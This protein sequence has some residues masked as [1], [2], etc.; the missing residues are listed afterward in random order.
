LPTNA[1]K[2]PVIAPKVVAPGAPQQHKQSSR[3]GKKAW[4]KN[5]DVTEIQEGLEELRD[6]VIKGFVIYSTL[7][8]LINSNL[9]LQWGYCRERLGGSFHARYRRRYFH[10][11][12]VLKRFQTSQSR[13]NYCTKIRSTSSVYAKATRRWKYNRWDNS[14]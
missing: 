12:T 4:R 9:I 11:Q 6:E 10:S 2:M 3:K 5:V 14:S 1:L 13:R 7:L 8:S